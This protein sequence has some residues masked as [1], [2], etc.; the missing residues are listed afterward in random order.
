MNP[1][2]MTGQLITV[3]VQGK[4]SDERYTPRWVFDGLGLTFDLDP[5]SPVEGGDCVPAHRKLTRLD[6]G[7]SADWNGLVWLNPPFSEAT[8]W[9]DKFRRHGNGVFLGPVANSRWWVDLIR[10]ADVVWHCRDIPFVS[11]SHRGKWSSMPL[12]FIAMGD[13]AVTAVTR[14]AM[15]GVHDG[16]LVQPVRGAS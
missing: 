9:A 11:P 5:A 7:L 12:A 2:D 16:V 10:V 8:A 3:P 1:Y 13:T 4:D 6:D 15:S 14:L